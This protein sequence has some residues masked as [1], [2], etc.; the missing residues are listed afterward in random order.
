MSSVNDGDDTGRT[1]PPKLLAAGLAVLAAG[2]LVG[3]WA[4]FSGDAADARAD[5]AGDV[6]LDGAPVET[7]SILFTP[8]DARPG[9]TAAAPIEKG[10]Y[11]I[12]R[13]AGPGLGPNTVEVRAQKRT[14]RRVQKAMAPAGELV[15]EVV[16]GVAARF[17][18][19]S[20]LRVEVKSGANTANFKVESK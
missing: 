10:K 1:V 16:E 17:N 4:L 11:R 19:K 14:G 5:I 20:E 3:A 9:F 6:T 8:A 2:L 12:A 13:A 15:D 7:G 18:V